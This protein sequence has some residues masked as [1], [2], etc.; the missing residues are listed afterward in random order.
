IEL[1]TNSCEDVE[2]GS[3]SA[4][5]IGKLLSKIAGEKLVLKMQKCAIKTEEDT[6][7]FTF[8]SE[9]KF[10]VQIGIA[11][12]TKTRSDISGDS[13]LQTKLEDGK[14]LVAISDGMGSGKEAKKSSSIAIKMLEKMLTSGFDR[15]NSIHM[16]NSILKANTEEDMYATLDI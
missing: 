15:D 13:S 9:D 5:K 16:I 14:Y 8:A 7:K 6:C 3:C 4:T 10:T 11:K 1:Y 12:A 2:N